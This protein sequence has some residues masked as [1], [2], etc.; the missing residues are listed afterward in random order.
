MFI[1]LKHVVGA[2]F[3]K[4]PIMSS[5][6]WGFS[7][8]AFLVS[9][10]V[11]VR[12]WMFFINERLRMKTVD[13]SGGK[14]HKRKLPKLGNSPSGALYFLNPLTWQKGF[15][16]LRWINFQSRKGVIQKTILQHPYL[17]DDKFLR[18]KIIVYLTF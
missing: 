1:H 16:A 9:W 2:C 14:C 10:T 7:N 11:S 3:I 5:L 15:V 12:P 6:S 13:K 17:F 18:I 4:L 8:L